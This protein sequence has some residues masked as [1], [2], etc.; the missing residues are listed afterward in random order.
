MVFCS[1]QPKSGD[2][3][4]DEAGT[5]ELEAPPSSSSEMETE[6]A[7]ERGNSF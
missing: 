2:R 6:T 5:A 1:V 3:K 7:T 4:P